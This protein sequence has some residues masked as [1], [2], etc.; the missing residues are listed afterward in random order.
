MVIEGVAE[1]VGVGSLVT[2]VGTVAFIIA[3]LI[4]A[5]GLALVA[6]TITGG[7]HTWLTRK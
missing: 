7:L 4:P 3:T 2:S 5:A 6:L 1:V